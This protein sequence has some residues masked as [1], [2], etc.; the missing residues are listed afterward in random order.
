MGSLI[1]FYLRLTVS[2]ISFDSNDNVSE[3][4][5]RIRR[6]DVDV[7]LKLTASSFFVCLTN[8]NAINCCCQYNNI[9]RNKSNAYEVEEKKNRKTKKK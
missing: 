5:N 8:Y 1:Q 4:D 6:N 9:I 2:S 7:R 3:S